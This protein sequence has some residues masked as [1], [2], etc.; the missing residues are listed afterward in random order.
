M[1]G[2]RLEKGKDYIGV[3]VGAL[4][5]EG[6]RVL[7]LQRLTPPEAG[8]WGIQG[9]AVEFGETVEAALVREVREELSVEVE[10]VAPLGV[11]DHILPDEGAHWVSPVF[12]V[13]VAVG[14]PRNAEP[15]KHG[16]LR[17]FPLDAPPADLTLTARNAL[18]LLRAYWPGAGGRDTPH[19]GADDGPSDWPDRLARG[20]DAAPFG[21]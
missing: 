13:R 12:L 18:R 21:G 6:G 16:E 14:T 1:D 17:W 7:L 8:R 4:I 20:D 11:T 3:G 2:A 9:G 5:A 15:A 10:I 19:L